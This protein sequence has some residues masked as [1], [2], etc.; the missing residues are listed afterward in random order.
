[1]PPFQFWSESTVP[2]AHVLRIGEYASPVWA[3]YATRLSGLCRMG[4]PV[5]V[6][7]APCHGVAGPRSCAR[8]TG[9]SCRI[10]HHQ[11]RIV[12]N[13]LG[14]VARRVRIMG[15]LAIV[16]DHGMAPVTTR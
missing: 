6:A 5:V 2:R 8:Y 4:Q 15:L 14:E 7:S 13:I 16:V 11:D 3:I 12:L 10:D 1:M 9:G